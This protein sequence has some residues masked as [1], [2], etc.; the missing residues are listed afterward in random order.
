M[1]DITNL[2]SQLRVD[3]L[4]HDV[5]VIVRCYESEMESINYTQLLLKWNNTY[6]TGQEVYKKICEILSRKGLGCCLLEMMPLLDDYLEYTFGG[7][8]Y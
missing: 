2:L 8:N 6:A 4:E 1:D 5:D 7:L 3:P